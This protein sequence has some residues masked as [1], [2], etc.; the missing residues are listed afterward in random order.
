MRWLLNLFALGVLVA[1]TGMMGCRHKDDPITPMDPLPPELTILALGDSY[2][3]GHSLPEQ[4]SWPY[5]LADSLASRGT[6]LQNLDV[7]AQT[8]WTTKD[9]LDSL[10]SPETRERLQG[11]AYGLVTMMIGVNNQFQGVDTAVFSSEMD[12]LISLAIAMAG[13]RPD[14]VLGFSIPDYG[15][16]PTGQL[17]NAQAIAEEVQVHNEILAQKFLQA[18]IIMLDITPLSL[19]AGT[20][21]S[22]VARDGLHYSRE[23]YRRW[24]A[25][26]FPDV[27]NCL[28][29]E[30]YLQP[31]SP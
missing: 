22:L 26:M 17:F 18:G 2:T 20:E 28:G 9:L 16:T 27:C 24:V 31:R 30:F 7:V 1:L 19:E 6:P 10:R 23:M 25:L 14:R 15:V 29:V 3:V 13:D 8:G 21:A 4:W 12:T 5:Q 11:S